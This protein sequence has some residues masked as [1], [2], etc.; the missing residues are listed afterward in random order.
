MLAHI[1]P[2]RLRF[3]CE[4]RAIFHGQRFTPAR[5]PGP[6]KAHQV[7]RA[8]LPATGV[9]SY[10]VM[11]RTTSE[12]ITPLSSLL[13]AHA[14]DQIPPFGFGCPYSNGSLQVVTS[15]CWKMAL[16]DIISVILAQLPG[17]VP[18]GVPLVLL[19]VSSQKASTSPY[20]S[21]ARHAKYSL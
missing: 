11:S 13:R 20:L 18:R 17:P 1:H 5:I 15:P 4:T 19:P 9:T 8:P 6:P 7:P 21:Q 16:P 10:G 3:T 14:P 12:S 2:S